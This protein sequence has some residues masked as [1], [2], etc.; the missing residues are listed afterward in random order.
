MNH[1]ADTLPDDPTQLKAIIAEQQH[2]I[3]WLS[4]QLK[5]LNA[6][7]F[8]PSSEQ[9]DHGQLSLFN[10][11][12]AA[13]G[14]EASSPEATGT[15]VVSAHRRRGHRQALPEQLERVVVEHDLPE[16]EKRCPCGAPL[17][18]IGEDTSEQLDIIPAQIRVIRHVR[19]RYACPCCEEGVHS[20]PLPPQPIPKSNASPGLLAFLV[21]S[22]FVDGLPLHR[23]EKQ[24]QRL[25]VALTRA[26]QARWM[27]ALATLLAPLLTLLREELRASA[28]IQ[29]DETV[30]QVLKEPQRKPTNPSYMWVQCTGPPERPIILYQYHHSRAGQVASALLAD[31]T[32]YVQSDGYKAYDLAIKANPGIVHC[33]CWAHVRRKFDDA[34]KAQGTGAKTGK[35]KEGLAWIAQLYAIE[36]TLI[37]VAPEQRALARQHQGAAI[38]EHMRQWLEQSVH[39]VPPKSLTGKA[40]GYALGEWDKLVRYLEDGR[41]PIDNNRC[42]NAIRPFVIGRKNWLFA[43]TPAG[44]DASAALYS[45]VETAKANGLEPYRYL[46]RLF[47]ELPK[48]TT[49]A[50]LEMLLPWR[51]DPNDLAQIDLYQ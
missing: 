12:E 6:R 35:A 21:V 48:A 18:R 25:G 20:A 22:K 32:G 14:A 41:I 17:Q 1:A 47:A 26:T 40:I 45:L 11:A 15:I 31:V 24:F 33:G 4:E 43:D 36:K 30:V 49:L 28:L 39:Q 9:R 8:G 5:L 3:D 42:E 23:I 44:A 27:I 51:I 34:L 13:S 7:R 37:D 16:A 19:P 46:R 10:E 38:L 50:E 2:Q 29:M